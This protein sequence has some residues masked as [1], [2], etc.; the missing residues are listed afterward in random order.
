V[1]P[2]PLPAPTGL[3]PNGQPY[4]DP[5]GNPLPYQPPPVAPMVP[6]PPQTPTP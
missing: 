4:S 2:S 6:A 3:R 5:Q 1:D